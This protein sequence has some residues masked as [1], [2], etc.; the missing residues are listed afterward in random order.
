MCS[1]CKKLKSSGSETINCIYQCFVQK[2]NE[3]RKIQRNLVCVL[4][5]RCVIQPFASCQFVFKFIVSVRLSFN[6]ADFLSSAYVSLERVLTV[7]IL[8]ALIFQVDKC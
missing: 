3:A 2:G 5:I 8:S 7:L 4:L 1:I 6:V